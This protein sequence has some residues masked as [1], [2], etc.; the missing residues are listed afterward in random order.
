MLVGGALRLVWGWRLSERGVDLYVYT[1]KPK[2]PSRLEE[3]DRAYF[4]PHFSFPQLHKP[5]NRTPGRMP[6]LSVS[7]KLRGGSVQMTM[8]GRRPVSE[9]V[10]IKQRRWPGN[11]RDP[12]DADSTPLVGCPLHPGLQMSRDAGM[13]SG[14]SRPGSFC[15]CNQREGGSV[16]FLV[17][18]QRRR[19]SPSASRERPGGSGFCESSIIIFPQNLWSACERVAVCPCCMC[20]RLQRVRIACE[21][22]AVCAWCM[23]A[24]CSM[25]YAPHALGLS[26]VSI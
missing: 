7:E 23:W 24:D 4:N 26:R 16:F 20:C 15:S 19:Q 1:P 14:H 3:W 8:V 13:P 22:V 25:F 17:Q 5:M 6:F 9:A 11:N 12:E 2:F 18:E 10:G 21:W